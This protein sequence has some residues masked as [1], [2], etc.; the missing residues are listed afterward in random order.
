[1]SSCPGAL[2]RERPDCTVSGICGGGVQ[3]FHGENSREVVLVPW[4]GSGTDRREYRCSFRRGQL[5]EV[6]ETR[7]RCGE[8]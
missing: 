6:W 3:A 2:G 5:G 4:T 8:G 1:M 7:E